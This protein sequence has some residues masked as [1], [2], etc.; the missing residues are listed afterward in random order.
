MG[1]E[2]AKS[3]RPGLSRQHSKTTKSI[4]A[5]A[6]ASNRFSAAAFPFLVRTAGDVFED[7][8]GFKESSLN[9]LSG[10]PTRRVLEPL[11]SCCTKVVYRVPV[12]LLRAAD[13]SLAY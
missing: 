12:T 4:S 2:V 9:P 5:R 10:R 7:L 8:L 3:G 11:G 1:L 13:I 6:R